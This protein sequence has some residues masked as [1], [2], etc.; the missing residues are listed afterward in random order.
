MGNKKY[1]QIMRKC[2]YLHS[3]DS[4]L[5]NSV[6]LRTL[7]NLSFSL[8]VLMPPGTL[9]QLI[10]PWYTNARSPY[11]FV[12][13][14]AMVSMFG[15]DDDLSGRAGVYTFKSSDRYFGYAVVNAVWHKESI[16]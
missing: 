5:T 8:T 13:A 11:D 1:K 3:V 15:S 4:C 2:T 10:G 14:V 9:F 7:L 16:L 12:L 6:V